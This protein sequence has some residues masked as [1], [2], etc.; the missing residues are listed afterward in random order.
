VTWANR[1]C[2]TEPWK[3]TESESSCRRLQIVLL[4]LLSAILHADSAARF[5][6][7]QQEAALLSAKLGKHISVARV[8][9]PEMLFIANHGASA[10][11][12]AKAVC[13][14]LQASQ[15]VGPE[16]ITIDRAT[17]TRGLL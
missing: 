12:E 4:L 14:A 13:Q 5:A 2:R 11:V 6:T 16:G 1:F 7:A 10:E 9:R 17:T 8:L 3:F 15:V